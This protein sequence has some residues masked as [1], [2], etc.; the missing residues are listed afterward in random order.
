MVDVNLKIIFYLSEFFD[1][2]VGFF[3]YILG[4]G[5]VVVVVV[6]GVIVIEK[7]FVLD[8]NGGEVDV[9]FFFEFYEIKLFVEEM[10]WVVVVIGKVNYG[11]IEWEKV[12]LV[13]WCFLYIVKDMKVGDILNVENLCFVCLGFGLFF[14][15][16]FFLFGK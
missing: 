2:Y 4:V 5:V 15:Y 7:Y 11:V 9:E 3:D 8:R 13:Y 6:F 14:K 16:F 10:V 1:C 12:L